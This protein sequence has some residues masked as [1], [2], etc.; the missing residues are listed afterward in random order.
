MLKKELKD[1]Y[2]L[3]MIKKIL[4]SDESKHSTLQLYSK[5][6]DIITLYDFATPKNV[7]DWLFVHS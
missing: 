6:G 2:G 5:N 7:R 1:I 4:T 3:K